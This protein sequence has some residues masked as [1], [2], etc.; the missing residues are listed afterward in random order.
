MP[1]AIRYIEPNEMDRKTLGGKAER[2]QRSTEYHSN[3]NYFGGKQPKYLI[4]DEDDPVDDN[5]TINVTAQGID[6]TISFLF[7]DTPV[8]Q[9]DPNQETPDEEWLNDTFAINGGAYFFDIVAQNGVLAG[10]CYVKV[11]PPVA[12][13][14]YPK[15]VALN[16]IVPITYWKADDPSVVLWHELSWTIGNDQLMQDVINRGTFWEI[17]DYSKKV[18]A[19]DW[20]E[21]SRV[22][23]DSYVAPIINWPHLPR[24]NFFYGQGEITKNSKDLN[25]AINRVA[26]DVG[27]ILRYHASPKTVIIGAEPTPA[28]AAGAENMFVINDPNAKVMNL[29]MKSDLTASITFLQYLNDAFLTLSRVVVMRGTVKDFQRVTNTGVRAVFMDMIA[30]NKLLRWSYG[31]GIQQMAQVILFLGGRQYDKF[32]A[33]TWTDPLPTD[34]TEV[35]GQYQIEQANGWVDPKTISQKLGW[36]WGSVT[37]NWKQVMKLPFME[38]VL[39]SNKPAPATPTD[40]TQQPTP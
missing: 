13:S 32:P 8:L 20:T 10:H 30:K 19:N 24:P 14:I 28:Q 7:P 35:V 39:G 37:D 40:G 1:A 31:I 34:M 38:L 4:Q 18:V 33:I 36:E 15:L 25:N 2:D 27:K 22:K 11:L 6:R 21:I 16:P 5:I 23:W 9:L 12:P 17:V 3:L 29:E 26:S